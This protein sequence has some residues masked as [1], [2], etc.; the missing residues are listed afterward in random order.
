MK[1][2]EKSRVQLMVELKRLRKEHRRGAPRADAAPPIAVFPALAALHAVMSALH[3]QADRERAMSDALGALCVA[4]GW[5]VGLFWH[6]ASPQGEL[7]CVAAWSDPHV[8]FDA[9]ASLSRQTT[10]RSGFG[11]LGR[12]WSE[13]DAG[14]LVDLAMDHRSPRALYLAREGLRWAAYHPIRVAGRIV[15][16]FELVGIDAPEPDPNGRLLLDLAG[17]LVRSSF[18]NEP[19]PASAGRR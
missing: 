8:A 18:S 19:R 1:D 3:G 6:E 11:P 7:R 10:F 15:G 14:E 9:I 2:S 16:A 17:H 12:A 4:G 13:A 5:E